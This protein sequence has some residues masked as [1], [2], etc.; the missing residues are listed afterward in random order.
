[1]EAYPG[2]IDTHLGA[3]EWRLA[4]E[5]LSQR[6]QPAAMEILLGPLQLFLDQTRLSLEL[7]WSDLEPRRLIKEPRGLFLEPLRLDLEQ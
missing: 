5:S 7:L 4:P 6:S 2:A 3:M 1:M